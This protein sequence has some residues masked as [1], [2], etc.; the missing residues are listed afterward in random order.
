[1]PSLRPRKYAWNQSRSS[2]I[3]VRRFVWIRAAFEIFAF[4]QALYAL[5]DHVDVGLEAV[6]ELLDDFGDELLVGEVLSLSVVQG[7]QFALI[8]TL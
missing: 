3:S 5:L 6:G 8:T 7:Q 4:H 1:M 2:E